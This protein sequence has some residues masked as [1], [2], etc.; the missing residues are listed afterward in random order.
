MYKIYFRIIGKSQ[1]Y[2]LGKLEPVGN[3]CYQI[4]KIHVNNEIDYKFGL[5]DLIVFVICILPNT[6]SLL[7]MHFGNKI[8]FVNQNWLVFNLCGVFVNVHRWL[9][10]IGVVNVFIMFGY[11]YIV[12]IFGIRYV[13][14]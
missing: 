3:V 1:F 13:T 12:I 4:I 11:N 5:K 10:V 8:S 2:L 7:R 14:I 9:I 6:V